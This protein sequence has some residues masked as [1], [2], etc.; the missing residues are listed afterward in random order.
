MIP[1]PRVLISVGWT[2]PYG[3]TPVCR[4]KA[5]L[6][7]F[8]R[9][10]VLYETGVTFREWVG[11]SRYETAIQTITG[12]KKYPPYRARAAFEDPEL[13]DAIGDEPISLV[14]EIQLH[15]SHYVETRKRIHL[16][17]I[18]QSSATLADLVTECRT[19]CSSLD[20]ADGVGGPERLGTISWALA[21]DT[22]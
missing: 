8:I 1:W 7:R 19:I 4:G 10:N 3:A 6:L 20:G 9:V 17:Q 16:W 13:L 22:T 21:T 11:S 5:R 14:C 15:L 18:V 2:V 12:G